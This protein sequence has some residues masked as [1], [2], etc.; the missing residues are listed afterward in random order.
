M[1]LAPHD[2]APALDPVTHEHSVLVSVH[3]QPVHVQLPEAG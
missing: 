1:N 2:A 3:D